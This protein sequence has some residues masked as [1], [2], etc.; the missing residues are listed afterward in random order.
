M[1]GG[2]GKRFWPWS[3]DKNPK[4]FLNIF[5]KKSLI[6]E[7]V[8]RLK[9]LV[10]NED[11]YI[12]TTS[13]QKKK[14][15]E[16]IKNIPKENIISEPI[17]RDTATC[18]GLGAVFMKEKNPD[19]VQVVLPSDHL[20]NN[21][22]AFRNVLKKAEKLA[23]EKNCL[24]TIGIKPTHPNTGYGYI[25]YNVDK[26]EKLDE[27]IYKV[28]TF[29]EKPNLE[30][31]QRFLESGDFLWNSGIFVWKIS[32]ILSEIEKSLPELYHEL[33]LI[34]KYP[35][36]KNIYSMIRKMY[37]RI[38]SISIDY[39]IMEKAKDVY[40]IK[41]DF[42]WNDVGSWSEVYRLGKKD[43][44]NNVNMGNVVLR[45]SK[46]NLIYSK[47]KL[48]TGIDINDMIIIDTNDVL[49]VCPKDKSQNVKELVD[50]LK[51]KDMKEFL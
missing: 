35:N 12:I 4:Q 38:R 34:E 32:K 10:K 6:E 29:A 14:T 19:E 13:S 30:T 11:I 37:S 18:I 43:K 46:G 44:N 33:M 47:K 17:G 15:A 21:V 1:A 27:G 3:R 49:L 16:L 26:K 41:A 8:D 51:R 24:V 5:S 45:E 22:E 2:S 23:A 31:A 20:I 9:S 7:T 36:K 40:V 39:G 25:Q 28:K 42:G 48:L 50:Y